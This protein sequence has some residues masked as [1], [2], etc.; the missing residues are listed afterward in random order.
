[1]SGPPVSVAPL[2]VDGQAPQVTVEATLLRVDGSA[3]PLPVVAAERSS[4]AGQI[5]RHELRVT[6]PP[7]DP[8]VD[9]LAGHSIAVRTGIRAGGS[10]IWAPQGVCRVV[11]APRDPDTGGTYLVARSWEE[12]VRRADLLVDVEVSGSAVGA[13]AGL[14]Q[15]A[16]PGVSLVVLV[17]DVTI[18]TMLLPSGQDGSRWAAVEAV[19]VACG[20]RV[21]CDLDGAFVVGVRAGF[22]GDP[23]WTIRAGVN[24]ASWSAGRVDDDTLNVVAV[25]DQARRYSGVAVDD[26]PGSTT[27]VGADV[28][29]AVRAGRGIAAM[30]GTFGVYARVVEL[31]GIDS[32]AAATAAAVGILAGACSAAREI[33]A[34][35]AWQPWADVDDRVLVDV[36]GTPVIELV[37][38]VT[39]PLTDLASPMRLELRA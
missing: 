5:A 31:D 11:A 12:L 27:F 4:S 29:D 38:A 19:S 15:G 2:L 17:D 20:W 35:A 18:P 14:L 33:D 30:P 6:V 16:V 22:E 13:I 32:D 1:M 23:D 9:W 34:D 25:R 28:V 3:A 39:V 8:P 24:A 7:L 21:W 36:D 10:W 37:D 26:R